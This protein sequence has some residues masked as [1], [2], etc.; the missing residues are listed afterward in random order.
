MLKNS[1]TLLVIVMLASSVGMASEVKPFLVGSGTMLNA[2]VLF[3]CLL[4][5]ISVG[6][7]DTKP[8]A[9]KITS[10]EFV[11]KALPGNK[12]GCVIMGEAFL[13][14]GGRVDIKNAHISCAGSE[15][16]GEDAYIIDQPLFLHLV[17][18]KDKMAWIEVDTINK[19]NT[20][21][22]KVL[23]V[24]IKKLLKNTQDVNLKWQYAK[25]LNDLD[26]SLK[27]F[28]RGERVILLIDKRIE[29][30]PKYV[31]SFGALDD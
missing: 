14:Y 3:G 21:D 11:K 22:K 16:N 26:I 7:P 15:E 9:I 17:S 18:P 31:G 13:S 1:L 12:T 24:H 10:D 29:L 4:P 20:L 23:R 19:E 6:V 2:E 30:T 27:D 28:P 5:S 25:L 8:V